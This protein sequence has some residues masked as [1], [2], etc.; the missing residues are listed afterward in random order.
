MPSSMAVARNQPTHDSPEASS[1]PS[2][3][4]VPTTSARW[5]SCHSTPSTDS[6]NVRPLGPP[7]SDGA[8]EPEMIQPPSPAVTLNNSPG[9]SRSIGKRFHVSRSLEIHA[10]GR[11]TPSK[12]SSWTL[13]APVSAMTI[14]VPSRWATE[15]GWLRIATLGPNGA[16][17]MRSQLEPSAEN[18]SSSG[19]K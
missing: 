6:Q 16:S 9:G 13:V 10:A 15:S 14:Q 8:R 5:N 17:A 18:H 2:H 1:W 19:L 4:G 7:V 11:P 3:S 12:P